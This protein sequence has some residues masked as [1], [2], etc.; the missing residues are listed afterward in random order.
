MDQPSEEQE[1]HYGR[2][3]KLNDRREQASLQ[4]LPQAGDE[5]TAQGR[6]YISC[7]SLAC[8]AETVERIAG[9]HKMKFV[10]VCAA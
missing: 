3:T 9:H 10:R 8:H 1:P 5:K 6:D 4:Q 2:K 7:R